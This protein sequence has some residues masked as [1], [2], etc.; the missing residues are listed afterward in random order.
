MNVEREL[1]E[2]LKRYAQIFPKA[3]KKFL[4]KLENEEIYI[5]MNEAEMRC[6]LFS[7]CLSIMH[8]EN[9]PK[10]F[11]ITVEDKEILEGKR[12]DI[13]LGLLKDGKFVG[14]ELKRFP[15]FESIKDDIKKL[16]E[17]VKNKVIFTFFGMIANSKYNYKKNINLESLGIQQEGDNSFY[18]WSLIEPPTA[19]IKLETLLV[20]IRGHE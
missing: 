8:E 7:E 13:S 19:K 15:D 9:F 10:P 12:A 20:G 2:E 11:E 5:P 4:T 14:V 16:S 18:E 3:W 1:I 17:F 6:Y